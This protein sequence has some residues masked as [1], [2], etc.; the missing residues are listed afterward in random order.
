MNVEYNNDN[1]VNS[2]WV[3]SENEMVEINDNCEVDISMNEVEYYNTLCE[4]EAI[5]EKE[6]EQLEKDIE[7]CNRDITLKIMNNEHN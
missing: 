6:R 1:V 3:D 7:I 5:R 4:E 2:I